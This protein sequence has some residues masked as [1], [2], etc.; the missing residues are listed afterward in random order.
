MNTT[1]Y[2]HLLIQGLKN[3][4][5]DQVEA[6]VAGFSSWA[7]GKGEAPPQDDIEKVCAGFITT[8]AVV[9]SLTSRPCVARVTPSEQ[10]QTWP[11]RA[12]EKPPGT[13]PHR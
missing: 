12:I 13:L 3:G 5:H 8:V 11:Y 9:K 1:D 2:L 6:S 10:R 7:R 4:D